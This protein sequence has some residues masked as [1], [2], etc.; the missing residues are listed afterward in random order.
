MKNSGTLYL[1]QTLESAQLVAASLLG[2]GMGWDGHSIFALVLCLW[3]MHKLWEA[4]APQFPPVPNVCITIPLCSLRQKSLPAMC[5][6]STRHINT[7]LVPELCG[8]AET[9][10]LQK[11]G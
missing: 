7:H 3:M 9:L 5:V 1:L 6:C 11:A 4:S 2:S 8:R 10:A